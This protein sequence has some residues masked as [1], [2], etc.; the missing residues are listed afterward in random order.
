MARRVIPD[1][2]Y[3]FNTVTQTIAVRGYYPLEKLT[4]ITNVTDN[5]VMYNFSDPT[6]AGTT[7]VFN[8]N[9]NI[10][11]ITLNFNTASM[12]NTDVIQVL[13]D[14]VDTAITASE[15]MND[16]VN[17][18]RVSSP[19]A[20]IDTDFEY[21]TQSTKWETVAMINYQAYGY[22][23]NASAMTLTTFTAAANGS[24]NIIITPNNSLVQGQP[25]F[26]TDSGWH[27][28]DG[29]F[30]VITA[31]STAVVLNAKYPF[32]NT[33]SNNLL[34][35]ITNGFKGE[36]Y[37]GA[38]IAHTMAVTSTKL[39]NVTTTQAHG[40]SVGNEVAVINSVASASFSNSHLVVSVANSTMFTI[41]PTSAPGAITSQQ[42]AYLPSGATFHRAFDGGVRF[43]TFSQSH[44]QQLVRQTRRYFRYQSGKGIQISTGTILEPEITIDSLTSSGTTVTVITKELHNLNPGAE[45]TLAGANETA[46]NGSFTV[47]NVLTPYSLTYTALSTPTDASA[48]GDYRLSVSSWH[49]A[50]AR[51]GLFDDAN[52][53]FF[54]YD[55]QQLYA[56]V[57]QSIFQLSGG[58][59][60]TN[61]NATI[62]ST[63]LI[64][65]AATRFAR[66]LVPG[67][68]V[69][70]RGVPY[71]VNTI[72]S[73]TSMTIN[74]P[75]KGPTISAPS[76]ATITKVIDNR[77]P[78]SQWNLDPCDGTG[79][80]GYNLD[81]SKM[82]M[83]YIDYSWY[84]AG[85]IRWGFRGPDGNIVYCHK[86]VNN[87]KNYEAYMRSGNL[88]ARYETHTH[89]K[90]TELT[91]SLDASNTVSMAVANAMYWPN[92]GIV[93]V[94]NQTQ[95]EFV[96]YS[97]RSNTSLIGL[98]R[99]GQGNLTAT[100]TTTAGSP[101]L[102]M[103]DTGGLSEGMY[104]Q[105]NNASGLYIVPPDSFIVSITTNDSIKISKAALQSTTANVATIAS[106][107]MSAAQT[108][109][110]STTTP[111]QVQLHS[112]AFAPAISHWGT[113]VIMD[114]RFD[115]DKSFV[116]TQG[117]TTALAVAGA[118]T[119]V[120]QSFRISPS[121]HN[122]V[123]G[124]TVGAR[125]I[126]NRMQMVMRQL[127]LLSGGQ[128]LVTFVL[129][130]T[131]SAGGATAAQVWS[132]VGGSSLVQFINHS[133]AST[134]SGGEVIYGFFT[135]SSGGASNLT[136]TS[137]DLPLVRDLGNS[138][139]GGYA[140]QNSIYGSSNNT[141]TPATGAASVFPDGPDVVSIVVRNLTAS[142][143]FNIFS[144]LSWTEAQA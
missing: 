66:Q 27:G 18:M 120:L 35:S 76:Y 126:V 64:N 29:T 62:S 90:Y 127:D 109:T 89:A 81:L 60:L 55:G 104:V 36:Q 122:G 97:S 134:I 92:T 117:M 2:V 80:S 33:T 31:N 22:P 51:V 103:T 106:L 87:N 24:R 32:P 37:L 144:R 135:N 79:R 110:Y 61:N 118:A 86:I 48:S 133:T 125:E 82:Q 93:W 56:V 121:A 128:F 94:R 50:G 5:L 141:I 72:A 59:T 16:P 112:P 119:N 26:I 102:V 140:G 129:N 8:S 124:T 116:F 52:G 139:L 49:G 12:S 67:D 107:G 132:N 7:A 4:L 96:K 30:H 28:S 58:V 137:M 10:T 99:T 78:Q 69:M 73:D 68:T 39:V 44:G 115:D 75:Y 111:V 57:R 91:A 13:V 34:T 3:T 123:P 70:I 53:L 88:P 113:S 54:E 138:I 77:I 142:T 9:N 83:F 25:V 23:N 98:T 42:L 85:F 45:I 63:T 1:M 84:G 15:E 47:V 136:T 95:S 40:L 46:Y 14:E 74:P 6:F 143:S 11:T 43:S 71:K 101:T 20:L 114:G 130:G 105:S 108:F 19:Q 38:N 41:V 17:K 100:I 21:G 131:V 65:G